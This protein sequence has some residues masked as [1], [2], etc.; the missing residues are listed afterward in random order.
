MQR[1][2]TV[3]QK[4][5]AWSRNVFLRWFPNEK[6]SYAIFFHKLLKGKLNLMHYSKSLE[7]ILSKCM[8]YTSSLTLRFKANGKVTCIAESIL[9]SFLK[10]SRQRLEPKTLRLKVWCSTDR[11][12][13][14]LWCIGREPNPGRPRGR[15]AFYHWEYI[16]SKR[17]IDLSPLF[18]YR[19]TLK[20]DM[21]NNNKKNIIKT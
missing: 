9:P 5:F 10:R 17:V 11:A 16:H 18:T 2:Q 1:L 6:G 3:L 21:I 19:K 14:V 12:T 20:T 15:P 7:K 13:L 4:L 8:H